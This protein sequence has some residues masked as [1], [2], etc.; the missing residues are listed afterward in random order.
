MSFHAW[1]WEDTVDCRGACYVDHTSFT[2][3]AALVA[4]PLYITALLD[5]LGYTKLPVKTTHMM[6]K[7]FF[8]NSFN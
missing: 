2:R 5:A 1:G 8:K 3:L 6:R 7:H 4:P